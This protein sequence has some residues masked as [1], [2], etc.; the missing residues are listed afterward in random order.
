MIA[1]PLA[2]AQ[3]SPFHVVAP[4]TNDWRAAV[5]DTTVPPLATDK[6]K[7][8]PVVRVITPRVSAMAPVN[9]I[10]FALALTVT[11]PKVW[12]E[13]PVI[14]KVP[15]LLNVP[16]ATPRVRPCPA[17]HTEELRVAASRRN[18][19]ALTCKPPVE[20]PPVALPLKTKVPRPVL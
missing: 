7:V 8:L 2:A 20:T 6:F 13:V 16:L 12:A 14:S 15:P 5:A 11:A 9:R 17:V 18:V 1:E 3:S 19:P 4:L 10:V